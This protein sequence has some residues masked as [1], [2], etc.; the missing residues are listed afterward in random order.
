[1]APMAALLLS[2]N[3]VFLPGSTLQVSGP[4]WP[5]VVRKVRILPSVPFSTSSRAFWWAF[6]SRWFWPIIRNL[7]LSRAAATM[8][9]QSSRVVAMGFSHSTCL[10]AFR[11]AMESWA[12]AL[13]A[14][15]T[16]TASMAG[17][18]SISSQEE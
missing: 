14:T 1:M 15:Q 5:K 2:K 18:A 16:L 12:W 13:L 6:V 10:P 8:A 3:Q 17:S 4:P 9:S 11:A 7:P